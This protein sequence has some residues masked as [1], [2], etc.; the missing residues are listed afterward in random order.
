MFDMST[1]NSAYTLGPQGIFLLIENLTL[2]SGVYPHRN[3]FSN[4]NAV[5]INY[6]WP[7]AARVRFAL[8]FVSDIVSSA[9]AKDC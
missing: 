9:I 6:Q 8:S 5:T 1:L 4:V 3:F 7:D 2:A